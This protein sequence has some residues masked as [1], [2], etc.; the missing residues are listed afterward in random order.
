MGP[1]NLYKCDKMIFIADPTKTRKVK[2]IVEELVNGKVVNS[3]VEEIEESF[4]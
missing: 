4:E 3:T 2:K 1:K